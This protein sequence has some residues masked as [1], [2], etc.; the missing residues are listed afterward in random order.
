MSQKET[1]NAA[2]A[3]TTF[4][5]QLNALESL[6]EKLERGDIPLAEAMAAYEEGLKAAQ[7]CE[8]L[9]ADAQ[10]KLDEL[11]EKDS[12]SAG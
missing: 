4:E 8:S 9:L 5:S 10:S 1:P 3:A 11:A 12:E 7:Q 6:V 2:D